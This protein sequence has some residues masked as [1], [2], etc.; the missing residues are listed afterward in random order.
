MEGAKPGLGSPALSQSREGGLQVG[1]PQCAA[2][3]AMKTT[4]RPRKLG[5]NWNQRR[6]MN[7]AAESKSGSGDQSTDA[8][9]LKVLPLALTSLSAV[10]GCE[11]ASADRE[12]KALA[13]PFLWMSVTKTSRVESSM[14]PEPTSLGSDDHR[15]E[16]A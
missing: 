3:E 12:A 6:V 4:G 13:G 7:R 15:E 1:C 9:F 16:G 5:S 8:R 10:V 2:P 11:G 14:C